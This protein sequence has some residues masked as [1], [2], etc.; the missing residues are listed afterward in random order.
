MSTAAADAAGVLR[1]EQ[2][3]P[4]CV[5]LV[6]NRPQARNALSRELRQALASTIDRL[7]QDPSVRVLVL[8]GA[9]EAFCAGLDLKELAAA[10]PAQREEL[11]D[12]P[13][14]D[15][16][17][18]LERFPGPVI[19]AVN[20]PAVTG[21]FELAL[22]CDVLLASPSASFADTH[23]R[24]GV[25]PGWG[26]SQKLSR[27]IGINRARELSL[28]GTPLTAQRACEWGLVNRVVPADELLPTAL[29]MAQDMLRAPPAVLRQYKQLINEG[30]LLPLAAALELEKRTAARQHDD[31][32]GLGVDSRGAPVKPPTDKDRP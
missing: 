8:T 12:S 23:A 25:L 31:F 16:I 14:L 27:I 11:F 6:M 24:V 4:G 1:V 26:L 9:G 29:A 5:C 15:P 20:G 7:A 30:H 22:A 19:G 32:E 21:G 28:A 17:A 2:P 10:T 3:L 13:V 18:A